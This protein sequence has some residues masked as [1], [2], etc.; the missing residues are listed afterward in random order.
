MRKVSA[1]YVLHFL[2]IDHIYKRGITS[3]LNSEEYMGS[4]IIVNKTLTHHNIPETD[5]QW[6]GWISTCESADIFEMHL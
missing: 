6:K 4:F 2:I 3:L 1:G 5:L